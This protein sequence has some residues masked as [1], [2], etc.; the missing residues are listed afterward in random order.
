M[1]PDAWLINTARGSLVDER[2]LTAALSRR[3]I[4]GAA[5]DTFEVE[6]LPADSPLRGLDNVI[7]TPHLLG[8]TQEMFQ[9]LQRAA[10][11]NVGDALA[12]HVP[13]LCVNPD[14][15]PRWRAH[16]FNV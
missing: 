4:G 12:G 16:R 3:S 14:V 13:Q 1:K 9:S 15:V 7:L 11:A 6:P 5:L 2:A 10:V 8:H